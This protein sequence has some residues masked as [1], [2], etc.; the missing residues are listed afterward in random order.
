MCNQP[1]R[2]KGLST[3]H[4]IGQSLT[5]IITKPTCASC[6]VKLKYSGNDNIEELATKKMIEKIKASG[7]SPDQLIKKTVNDP[8]KMDEVKQK[9]KDLGV[10]DETTNE[11]I[12]KIRSNVKDVK[13]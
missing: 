7:K 8:K 11:T 12:N 13:E 9:A 4:K 6:L 1:I 2:F 5:Y 3:R 10:S